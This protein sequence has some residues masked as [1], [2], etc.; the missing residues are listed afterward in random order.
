MT[1]YYKTLGLTTEATLED[2]KIAYRK[3]SKK[4]HPDL[5]KGDKYFEERFK[6]IQ[7]AYE[8]IVKEQKKVNSDFNSKDS[9]KKKSENKTQSNYKQEN[10]QSSNDSR[11]KHNYLK[12]LFPIL[13]I[14]LIA[15]IKPIIQKSIRENAEKDLIKTYENPETFEDNYQTSDLNSHSNN[16]NITLDSISSVQNIKFDSIIEKKDI[17][18]EN[19]ATIN[20]SKQWLLSKLNRYIIEHNYHSEPSTFTFPTKSR[21]YNYYF[22]IVD[23]N[24]EVTY[25]VEFSEIVVDDETKNR[26]R[27]SDLS[28]DT[29]KR[30][31]GKMTATGNKKYKIIIPIKKIDNISFDED[32]DYNGNCDFSISTKRNEMINYNLS[33]NDKNYSS[34][35]SFEF[36]CSQEENLGKRLNDALFHIKKLIPKTNPSKNET[37]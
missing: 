6:E 17:E 11:K 27:Y 28:D 26:Y 14:I 12:I 20:E 13:I 36:D 34:Y 10:N 25:N 15:I 32:K 2:V 7:E 23:N 37:F 19:K 35:F 30:L 18:V 8:K 5:N 24:L 33:N 21:Y 3:L 9:T 4:F 1:E 31:A 29:V 22:I 16:S